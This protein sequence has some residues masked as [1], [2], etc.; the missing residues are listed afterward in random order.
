MVR[1]TSSVYWG[2]LTYRL[3]PCLVLLGC[4]AADSS[5]ADGHIELDASD[6]APIGT[7]DAIASVQ[8]VDVLDDGSVWVLNSVEPFLVGFGT[9]GSEIGEYGTRGGG[10]NEFDAPAGFVS[11]ATNA[12]AWVLDARRNTL[13]EV[14][15]PPSGRSEVV[16]PRDSVL[17]PGSLQPGMGMMSSRVRSARVGDELLVARSFGTLRSGVYSFWSAVWGADLVAVDW[18]GA[19]VRTV[20]S[21]AEAL[22][23]PSTYLEQT[24]GFPPVPLWFRLWTVCG[25]GAI[26]VHDRMRNEVRVFSLDGSERTSVALPP[27]PFDRVTREEFARAAFGLAAAEAAGRV[28][29]RLSQ[30]DSAQVM[31]GL[32]QAVQGTPERLARFLP[33]YVDMRCAED[34]ALWLQPLDLDLSDLRGG[35]DWIRIA[36]DGAVQDVR[37]PPR[38]D[39]YRFLPGRI[40]GIQRDE[41]D[42]ASV[43]WVELGWPQ[44]E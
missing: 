3:V 38:F 37:L 43:A 22:G 42:V 10:P 12:S 35:R 11:G 29:G 36:P 14:P 44:P 13:V 33:R 31:Q 24:N 15:T 8:D 7:S 18:S 28:G 26:R 39:A 41:L 19:S 4:G 9:D 17:P 34:G 2:L 20:V 27:A 40:L 25:D 32:V 16:L 1:R 5:S 6:V 23:D 21:L 30:E